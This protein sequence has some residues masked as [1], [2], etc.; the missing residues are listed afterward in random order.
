MVEISMTLQFSAVLSWKVGC[1]NGHRLDIVHLDRRRKGWRPVVGER[2]TIDYILGLIFRAARMQRAIRF[3]HRAGRCIHQFN[4]GTD[5]Q[6]EGC[7]SDRVRAHTIDGAGAMRVDQGIRN[8]LPPKT[9]A[10]DRLTR[11]FRGIADRISTVPESGKALLGHPKPIHSKGESSG[12]QIAGG[13]G[14]IGLTKLIGLR[15]QCDRSW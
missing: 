13:T 12:V 15:D 3:Q 4:G 11:R 8:L 2:Y 10:T 7:M 14:D 9:V 1:E 6:R 5:R